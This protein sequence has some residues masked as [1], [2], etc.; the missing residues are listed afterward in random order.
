MLAGGMML[1]FLV[2]ALVGII[3]T[4]LKASTLEAVENS[5]L[6]GCYEL[7]YEL[8]P[9]SSVVSESQF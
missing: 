6:S 9:M 5:A 3:E 1:L 8:G 7:F 4:D 2:E